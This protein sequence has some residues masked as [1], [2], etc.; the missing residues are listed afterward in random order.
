MRWL[1]TIGR[2]L[3]RIFNPP[4]P[5]PREVCCVPWVEG[6]RLLRAG[7]GWRLAREEDDNRVIGMVYLER[8]AIA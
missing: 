2:D 8:D 4:A 7:E 1:R 6:D 3:A 5:P